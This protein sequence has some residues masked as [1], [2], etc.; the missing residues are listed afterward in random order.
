MHGFSPKHLT[1][2]IDN[3]LI[4][5]DTNHEEGRMNMDYLKKADV[6]FFNGGDQS[7]HARC[8]L[9][10]DGTPSKMF[11]FILLRALSNSVILS[12]TSAG[13]MIM[14]SPIYGY[15]TTFGHLYFA[16]SFGLAIK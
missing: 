1:V 13:A 15:G 5:T 2:H 8:W 7:H 9:N 6:I 10:D 12:G 4:T 11:N 14:C 16:N 3:Y